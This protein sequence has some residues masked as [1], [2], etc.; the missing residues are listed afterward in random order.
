LPTSSRATAL[1]EKPSKGRLRGFGGDRRLA[2]ED[3]LLTLAGYRKQ[4]PEGEEL[5]EQDYLKIVP[6]LS[7]GYQHL[8]EVLVT[9]LAKIEGIEGP[10][11]E[12]EPSEAVN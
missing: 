2:L 6:L 11:A 7:P 8:I 4:V 10:T 12:S 5:S 1:F 3:R 9:E